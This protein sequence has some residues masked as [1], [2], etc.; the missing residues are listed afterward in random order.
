MAMIEVL[1]APHSPWQDGVIER[2]IGSVRPE[3]LDHVIV[4][5]AGGEF[6]FQIF[7]QDGKTN[8]MGIELGIRESERN[9]QILDQDLCLPLR[10]HGLSLRR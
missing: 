8:Q 5:N 9:P 6:D 7:V 10:G 1:T 4:F 2:F 3:C